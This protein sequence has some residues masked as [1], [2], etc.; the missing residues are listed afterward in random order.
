MFFK[1]EIMTTKAL[2]FSL[3]IFAFG[4]AGNSKNNLSPQEKK[5][6]LYYN[7]GTRDLVAGNYTQALKN[8]LEAAKIDKDNSQ[9]HN[10]LGMAY[11]FKKSQARAIQHIQRAIELDSTNSDAKLNLGSL[12]LEQNKLNEAQNIFEEILKDLTYEGQHRTYHNLGQVAL[13][14]NDLRMAIKRF[15]DAIQSYENYCPSHFQLGEIYYRSAQFEKAYE[16]Y[17]NAGIGTCVSNPEALWGQIDSLI[18]LK[19]FDE[20]LAKLSDMQERFAMTEHE[21][22]AGAKKLYVKKLLARELHQE[23]N[24]YRASGKNEVESLDF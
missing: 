18:Q 1:E 23:K 10:N 8:L 17:K 22:K 2:L 9:I 6:K 20:A 4:C 7:Q 11:Y 16:S 12:Y 21:R 24:T 3:L 13:K 15:T 19:K 14:R 5:A